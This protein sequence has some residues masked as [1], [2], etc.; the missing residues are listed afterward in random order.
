MALALMLL[1]FALPVFVMAL[2][3]PSQLAPRKRGSSTQLVLRVVVPSPP[4]LP[5][6]PQDV[7]V[8]GDAEGG[9]EEDKKAAKRA[10]HRQYYAENRVHLNQQV[11]F[12]AYNHLLVF[13]YIDTSKCIVRTKQAKLYRAKNL[14]FLK[15]TAK[16]H[17]EKNKSK[18][19][20]E[21]EKG[22]DSMRL[23]L[24]QHP[25]HSQVTHV[26]L[27]TPIPASHLTTLSPNPIPH[28][29]PHLTPTPTPFDS[30]TTYTLTPHSQHLHT[31]TQHDSVFHHILHEK[32]IIPGLTLAGR[33]RCGRI[34]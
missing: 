33:C 26:F 15:Q 17:H 13:L 34:I 20:L 3:T 29:Y 31:K 16:Q 24:A 6:P 19:D 14:L 4:R 30:Y 25:L 22:V 11:G 2:A 8:S 9:T 21:R 23:R 32:Q 18:Q 10:Y 12:I 27:S 28:Y 1:I 7:G 5:A